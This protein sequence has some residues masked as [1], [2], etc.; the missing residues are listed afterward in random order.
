LSLTG[1][2]VI[3]EVVPQPANGYT[4]LLSCR[5]QGCDNHAPPKHLRSSAPF[6]CWPPSPCYSRARWRVSGPAHW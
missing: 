4:T 2:K 5:W 1:G 6:W 3:A